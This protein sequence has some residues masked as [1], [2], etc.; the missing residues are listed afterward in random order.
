M[1]DGKNIEILRL[2]VEL[3][4]KGLK[5]HTPSKKVGINPVE[6]VSTKDKIDKVARKGGA[7][8]CGWHLRE[9]R[10]GFSCSR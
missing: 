1:Y 7:G 6:V 3:L 2:K 10:G 5:L 8:P 4:F 9:I